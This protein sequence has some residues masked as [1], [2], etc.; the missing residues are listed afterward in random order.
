MNA[1]QR[2]RLLVIVGSGE[3]TPTLARVHRELFRQ[4]PDSASGTLI[5]TTYGFQE[6]ADELSEKIVEYFATSVGRRFNVAR[7]RTRD[8]GPL[9]AA[10]AVA[11]IDAADYIVAGPGSPTY[12]LRHWADGPIADAL[13]RKMTDGGIVVMASAAAVTLGVVTMPVYEIY[14]VGADPYWLPGLDLLRAATGWSAAVVPHYD[15][16]EGGTHDTR[17]CYVGERRLRVLEAELPPDAFVLG[18]DSHSAL[19]LDLD[20]ATARVQGLGGVTVRV[21]GRS[22]RFEP[23]VT[24]PLDAITDAAA[25]LGAA[26]DGDAATSA[27]AT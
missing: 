5:D 4:L 26:V 24:V 1:T 11:T 19:V 20:A 21:R 14:K 27:A 6:N 10:T 22:L 7:Y 3:T 23:G 8:A 17:F 15:N 18:V 9:E 13:A 12:A 25:A 16:S 2:P